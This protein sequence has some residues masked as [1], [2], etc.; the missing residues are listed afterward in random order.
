M[1]FEYLGV[2]VIPAKLAKEI[3]R[4]EERIVPLNPQ[5]EERARRLHSEFITIDFHMHTTIYP[6]NVQDLELLSRS[7]RPPQ[8]FEGI[9]RSG[10]TACLNG[11]GGSMARRSSPVPWQF[12]DLIWDLGVRYADNDH[13]PETVMRACSVKDILAA[14]KNGRTALLPIIENAQMIE[15][16]LDRVDVLYGLGIRSMGLSYNSRTTLAD[17]CTERRD[18]GLSAFG[19]KVVERMNRLGMLIDL[20]HS[21]DL[22]SKEV[23]EASKVPCCFT[24]AFARRKFDNPRGK[25]DDLMKLMA[26]RGGVIGVSAVPNLISNKPVQT[27]FD[28]MDHLDYLVKL[29]GIEYVAIGTDCNFGDHVA[30]NKHMGAMMDMKKVFPEFPAPYTDYIENPGQWPNFCRAL[31]SR[32]Y[33]DEEIK[34]IVGGNVLRILGQTI[35]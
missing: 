19:L 6:E 18:G 11:F 2:N 9:K 10:L 15:N 16:D 32:G 25:P 24:H 17:G 33:S 20:S 4:I 3:G 29:V 21:S 7:G 5:D 31:V 23:I 8:A 27:I 13:H 35:G 22:T 30:I 34:K 26:D 12:Q 14:K 28:V 1:S